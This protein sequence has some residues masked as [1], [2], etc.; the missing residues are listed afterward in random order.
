MPLRC[1]LTAVLWSFV[2]ILS[3]QAVE[4]GAPD[5][6]WTLIHDQTVIDDL[7][8]SADQRQA[9]RS[10]LDPLDVRC[11]PLRNKPE[12]EALAG[13]AKASSEARAALGKI[14]KPQQV[15]RLDQIVVRAQGT[16]ALL[17]DD[18]AS[19][20][21]LAD[22]QRADIRQAINAARQSRQKLESELKT[23]KLQTAEAEKQYV[24][25]NEDERDAVN[26]VLTNDQKLRLG[27]LMAR[28]FDVSKLGRTAFKTP[29]L[30]ATSQSWVNAPAPSPQQLNGGGVLVVHFFAF[31][32][33]NCIHN[34]PTY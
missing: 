28:D 8:L 16:L 6:Y 25:I 12:K 24:K 26:G 11:F 4:L 23:A 10:V 21:K 32:C 1:F 3:A 14:L 20:L 31:G 19:T 9:W 27:P 2:V 7:K 30:I 34:Y 13:F 33:S 5:V 29:E 17:R 15:Q 22:K 18:L